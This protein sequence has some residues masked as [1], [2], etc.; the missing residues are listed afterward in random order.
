MQAGIVGGIADRLAEATQGQPAAATLGLLWFSAIASAIIDNI[1]YTATAIP[2]VQRLGEGGIAIEPLWWALA[3]GACLGGNLTIVG[4]SAN[5]VV[6]NVALRAGHPIRFWTVPPLRL[7]GGARV[8]GDLHGVRLAALPGVGRGHPRRRGEA[9]P[10]GGA[11]GCR[12]MVRRGRRRPA[13]GGQPGLGLG[14]DVLLAHGERE[15]AVDHEGHR[16]ADGPAVVVERLEERDDPV[17]GE[18]PRAGLRSSHRR[19]R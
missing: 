7:G 5:V 9:P 16:Q 19:W 18:R 10:V 1:P 8:A 14:H 17:R 13:A 6:S 12:A 15:R 11:S 4:A 3:L 2:V